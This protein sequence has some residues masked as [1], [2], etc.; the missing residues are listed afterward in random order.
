[1]DSNNLSANVLYHVSSRVDILDPYNNQIDFKNTPLTMFNF[2]ALFYGILCAM[3]TNQILLRGLKQIEIGLKRS[4]EDNQVA[5][6]YYKK[7]KLMQVIFKLIIVFGFIEC[8][9]VIVLNLVLVKLNFIITLLVE[10]IFILK[11]FVIC[12]SLSKSYNK[13]RNQEPVACQMAPRRSNAIVTRKHIRLNETLL[14]NYMLLT[15]RPQNGGTWW[16]YLL[17]LIF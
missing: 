7:Y 11:Y 1:M 9:S 8:M 14:G 5:I 10:F 4:T 17:N 15:P 3:Y 6:C 2:S 16:R 12:V 13:T